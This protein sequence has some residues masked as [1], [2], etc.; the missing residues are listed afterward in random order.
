MLREK[1]DRPKVEPVRWVYELSEELES[2]RAKL[3]RL[4]N[5]LKNAHGDPS[6]KKRDIHKMQERLPKLKREVAR[7]VS[8]ERSDH[9]LRLAEYRRQANDPRV[10]I[11]E[12]VARTIDRTLRAQPTG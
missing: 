2:R 10:R 9:E 12:R 1:G 7:S 5:Y 3:E 4:R 11:V 8:E 6:V